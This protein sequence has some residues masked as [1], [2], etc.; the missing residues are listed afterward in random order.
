MN[1]MERRRRRPQG[2]AVAEPQAE[3]PAVLPSD[4]APEQKEKQPAEP[5]RRRR[6][7]PPQQITQRMPKI[8]VPDE[9]PLH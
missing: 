9:A 7:Q 6:V 2:G 8:V 4:S 1:G 3:N 5:H